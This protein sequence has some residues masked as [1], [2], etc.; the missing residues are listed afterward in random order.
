MIEFLREKG[1]PE[2]VLIKIVRN[3]DEALL[4]NLSCNIKNNIYSRH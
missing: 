2:E 4:Y 1:M 3:N